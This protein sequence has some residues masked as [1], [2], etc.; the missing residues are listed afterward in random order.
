MSDQGSKVSCHFI[1]PR[2]IEEG[3]IQLVE[4]DQKAWHAGRAEMAMKR[5]VNLFSVAI[6]LV[7]NK[8][9]GFTD[10]QYEASALLCDHL[11]SRFPEISMNRIVGHDMISERPNGPGPKWRWDRFFDTLIRKMYDLKISR[12]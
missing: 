10:W 7:G 3:I 12:E 1:I 9:S 8:E 5:D 6:Q 2:N 11:L 4:L